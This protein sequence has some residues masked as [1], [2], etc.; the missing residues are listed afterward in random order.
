[1]AEAVTQIRAG[2]SSSPQG[3]WTSI[4][5]GVKRLGST[6]KFAIGGTSQTGGG[7]EEGFASRGISSGFGVDS[8]LTT[9]DMTGQAGSFG[10]QRKDDFNPEQFFLTCP[11][12]EHVQHRMR[13]VQSLVLCLKLKH[14]ENFQTRAAIS[15]II[16]VKAGSRSTS[17][18]AD[19]PTSEVEAATKPDPSVSENEGKDPAKTD[20]FSK[21][22]AA[23]EEELGAG[24]NEPN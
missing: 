18:P 14:H 5:A 15:S 7:T 17:A 19:G 1:M 23:S 21:I 4:L 2:R 9:V 10:T 3:A 13:R 22:T 24:E 8:S 20:D 16:R 6:G 12:S 11:A